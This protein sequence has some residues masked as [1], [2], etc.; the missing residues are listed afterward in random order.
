MKAET[1]VWI[2]I[3]NVGIQGMWLVEQMTVKDGLMAIARFLG[4]VDMKKSL[5]IVVARTKEEAEENLAKSAK[6]MQQDDS[7]S[8][9]A[10]ALLAGFAETETEE[11]LED[12]RHPLAGEDNWKPQGKIKRII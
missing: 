7:L 8:G 11:E 6:D 1:K 12:Y 9:F 4:A 5:R 10:D 2:G 3:R